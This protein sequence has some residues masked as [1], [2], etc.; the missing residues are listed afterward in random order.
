MSFFPYCI[1]FPIKLILQCSLHFLSSIKTLSFL[2]FTIFSSF[3]YESEEYVN[4]LRVFS[5]LC[6][7][8]RETPFS[9]SVPN[10]ISFYSFD[11]FSLLQSSYFLKF[12]HSSAYFFISHSQ[13]SFIHKVESGPSSEMIGNNYFV[14][15]LRE[16]E[17]NDQIYRLSHLCL[18]LQIQDMGQKFGMRTAQPLMAGATNKNQS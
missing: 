17:M 18:K 11:N 14:T 6:S 9:L 4:R 10:S 3:N 2:Y 1:F 5:N 8:T 7:E 13:L 16:V 12:H 15:V